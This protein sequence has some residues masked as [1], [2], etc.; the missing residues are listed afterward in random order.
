M[1]K[2]IISKQIAETIADLFYLN[3][4]SSLPARRMNGEMYKEEARFQR[5][6]PRCT[7]KATTATTKKDASKKAAFF[8]LDA[9]AAIST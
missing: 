5:R 6:A 1:A 7:Q 8:C 4:V 3:R 2:S 9:F